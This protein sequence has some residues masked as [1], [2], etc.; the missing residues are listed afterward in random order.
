MSD[1]FP[2]VSVVMSVHN[3]QAF[4]A[5]AIESILSQTFSNF[6]FIIINDASTDNSS[7]IIE[8]FRDQRIACFV[9][10]EKM[11]LAASLNK[12][13]SL[14]KGEYIARMDADDVSTPDR[15][16]KQVNFLLANPEIA[17]VG[18]NIIFIDEQGNHLQ[19]L[20]YPETSGL[21]RWSLLFRNSI[22]HPVVMFRKALWDSGYRYDEN[23]QA[24]QDYDLWSRISDTHNL[25][26]LQDYLLYYRQHDATVSSVNSD[27]QRSL[28]FDVSRRAISRALGQDLPV[29][30]I[31]CLR[32]PLKITNIALAQKAAYTLIDLYRKS[33]KWDM[34]NLERMYIQKRVASTLLK[35]WRLQNRSV[36]LW[37][38]VLYSLYLNPQLIIEKFGISS[39]QTN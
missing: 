11:G 19:R 24:T 30:L 31:V 15:L 9:N 23:M 34:Q 18:A 22:A 1:R 17:V 4:L 7:Q 28:D 32:D 5:Q 6:E 12:G 26:N 38:A 36:L 29:E 13:I 25:Y 35:I 27:V 14:A 2:V 33:I 39:S 8:S 37:F 20:N 16:E 3:G 10:E 21:I